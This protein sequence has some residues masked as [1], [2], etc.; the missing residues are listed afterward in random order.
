MKRSLKRLLLPGIALFVGLILFGCKGL[1]TTE[2]TTIGTTLPPT[3]TTT[4]TTAMTTTSAVMTTTESTTATPSTTIP[5]TI[6]VS[7]IELTTTESTIA[8]TYSVVFDSGGGTNVNPI[9]ELSSGESI[10][11][12]I[13]PT[14]DGFAFD[15]W[16][17]EASFTNLWD[18][19]LD[20][21][22]GNITLYANWI[23][24]FE[25]TF[26]SVGGSAVESAS[27]ILDGSMIEAPAIPTKSGLT[28]MGWY[29]EAT[30]TTEWVFATDVVTAD[31][32]LYAKWSIVVIFEEDH[33]TPA[34]DD[35]V[36][37]TSGTKLN[38]PAAMTKTG[39]TFLGWY[40]ENTFDTVWNFTIDTVTESMTLYA[41]W[42]IA[43]QPI[44]TKEEFHSLTMSDSTD[45]YYLVNDLDFT[46]FEW[47]ESGTGTAFKGM[48]NG[49]GKTLSNIT[50]SCGENTGVYGGLFQRVNG[51][52][53][54]NLIIDHASVTINGRAGV[55]VGRIEGDGATL[56]N[57][58]IRNSSVSG[59]AG[60]GTGVL[61]GNASYRLTASRITI[62]NSSALN[63]GKN[64][65]FLAGRADDIVNLESFYVQNSSVESQTY[66]TDAGV[67]GVIGYTNK[68]T[69][70]LSLNKVVLENC[71]L[72]GRSSGALVGFYK[73]GALEVSDAFLDVEFPY[74]SSS[75]AEQSGIIGRRTVTDTLDPVLQNV[76]AHFEGSTPGDAIQLDSSY[77]IDNMELINQ[78]WWD[79]NIT[80]IGESVFWNYN[81][82]NNFYTMLEAVI[83][84]RFTVSFETNGAD[85]I[86][87]MAN[88]IDG[89]LISEPLIAREGFTLLGWYTDALL[90]AKWN[91]ETDLVTEDLTLYASWEAIVITYTLTFDSVEGSLVDPIAD[92][93]PHSTVAAPIAPTKA[94]YAFLGWF[95]ENTYVTEWIFDTTTVEGNMTLYAKWIEVFDV[96]FMVNG[97]DPIDPLT[98]IHLGSLITPPAAIKTGFTFV[99]WFK[100][101]D[102]LI[103]WV[104]DTDQVT[105]DITLYAQWMIVVK[106]VADYG[107]PAP[108]DILDVESGSTISEPA[109]MTKSGAT[110]LGWYKEATFDTLWNFVT[111]T[112]TANTTIYA[113]WD[114]PGK[115]ISTAQEFYDMTISGSDGM[116][117]LINNIDF[118]GFEW[119]ESGS[120][121]TF[122]GVLNGNGKTI[123]NLTIV[124]SG[125]SVYGGVFQR[126]NGASILDLT[127]DAVSVNVDGRAGV[128]IGRIES[129]PIT[130]SNVTILNSA[131]TGTASEGAGI[132]VGNA[133]Y[134]LNGTS[135]IIK[136][137]IAS[138]TNKYV[139]ILVG[140]ADREINVTDLFIDNSKAETSSTGT[141]SGAG[142]IVGYTNAATALIVLNRAVIENCEVKGGVGGGIVGY[143]KY[144]G[145]NITDL[146]LDIEFTYLLGTNGL[147]GRR[148]VDTNTT[149]PILANVWAHFVNELP[150]DKTVPL[151]PSLMLADLAGLD[152]DWW[153]VHYANLVANIKWSYNA[154]SHFFELS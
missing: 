139:G 29:K 33:G 25:V 18:F 5:T 70:D 71:I 90:S 19:S 47:I 49:N 67:G 59:T 16:Y 44:S 144:G 106:F 28:F 152:N 119:I 126:V 145:M 75:G 65:G 55:L 103:P 120:G 109:T 57:I 99:G 140:R 38:E 104:A 95:T 137:S 61:V 115:I 3:T 31:I 68:A 129:A 101:V 13:Q 97:G 20:T 121:T 9:S 8:V 92:I 136:N 22:T 118:T 147:I 124:G 91:F 77:M 88:V 2:P 148:N 111:D 56:N 54:A 72:N 1:S 43:G 69:A 142:G 83:L 130:V 153:V 15:G 123:S 63:T 12:P 52:M 11:A 73:L 53:I 24:L 80:A 23:E 26:D 108:A 138:S 141:D 114:I 58:T 36:D 6:E 7:T 125:T 42:S 94:G 87:P 154:T 135:I 35:V 30:Y 117:T 50:I 127:L 41:K 10:D 62:L 76:Y 74:D 116:F 133:T 122:K 85:P 93:L 4:T 82:V 100:D 150:G 146:F 131:V 132:L 17:K 40:K 149:D 134:G 46:G 51:A 102:C 27:N 64:V 96:T 105:A 112:V 81:E 143:Y 79:T 98:N 32:T 110:F 39:A 86:D 45:L 89:S 151:D 66:N 113:K 60:E 34:P 48:L 84:E 21:V 107:T 14:K 37:V 78:T 128:L